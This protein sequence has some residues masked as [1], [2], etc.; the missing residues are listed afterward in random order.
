MVE[1]EILNVDLL[2]SKEKIEWMHTDDELEVK[3]PLQRIE[4]YPYTIRILIR[5]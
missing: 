5:K 3:I 2:G 4:K 1:G